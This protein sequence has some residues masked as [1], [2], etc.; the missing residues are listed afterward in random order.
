[1]NPFQSIQPQKTNNLMVW[2]NCHIHQSL[3]DSPEYKMYLVEFP[4]QLFLYILNFHQS[5]QDLD[6]DVLE[7]L[8]GLRYSLIKVVLARFPVYRL[9]A[10]TSIPRDPMSFS[11]LEKM[12]T[13]ESLTNK[14]KQRHAPGVNFD[15]LKN[16]H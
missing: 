15:D 9:D 1:M 12:K 2:K 16:P 13:M 3:H 10:V 4:N 6:V 8:T 5:F 14:Q 7:K 11:F